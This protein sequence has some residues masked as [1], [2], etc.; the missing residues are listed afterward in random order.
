M[1]TDLRSTRGIT[2]SSSLR[3]KI[4]RYVKRPAAGLGALA[5][6]DRTTASRSDRRPAAPIVVVTTLGNKPFEPALAPIWGWAY[7]G[8][9]GFP[10]GIVLAAIDDEEEWLELSN[11]TPVEGYEKVDQWNGRC[12]FQAAL[13]TFA[14]ANGRHRLRLRVKTR[15]GEVAAE[16]EVTFGVN[17]VGPL[18]ESTGAYSGTAPSRGGSGST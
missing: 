10:E 2:R 15:S 3:G 1:T 16:R 5:Q 11:R 12:G 7:S 4:A 14:L 9:D 17:N 6:G 13:N 18:A 8:D